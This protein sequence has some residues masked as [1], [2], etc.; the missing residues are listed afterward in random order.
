MANYK[1]VGD[2]LVKVKP[3]KQPELVAEI[4]QKTLTYH[5]KAALSK[6]TEQMCKGGS[7]KL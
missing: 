4:W 6:I 7:L 1:F 2:K 3:K 5:Q